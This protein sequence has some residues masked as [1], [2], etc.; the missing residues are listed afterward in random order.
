MIVKIER[1]SI[2]QYAERHNQMVNSMTP[3]DAQV[4]SATAING[5]ENQPKE[6][7]FL[8]M[9]SKHYF[10]MF[11]YKVVKINFI[12]TKNMYLCESHQYL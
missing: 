10:K 2:I 12:E 4:I 9:V 8:F 3:F 1:N 11:G 5:Y 6:S 7:A